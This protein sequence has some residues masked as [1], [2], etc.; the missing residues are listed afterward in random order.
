MK[1]YDN[2]NITYLGQTNWRN[3]NTPFG[4]KDPDRLRHIYCIGKSGVGKSNLLSTMAI[5]DIERGAAVGILDPH[6]DVAENLLNFI[7]KDRIE[8]VIYFNP[9]DTEFP[10]AFNPLKSIHPSHHELVASGLISTFSR[11]W[12]NSWGVRLEYILKFCLLTLLEYRNG[13]LLDINPLLTDPAFRQKVLSRCINPY[14]LAYWNNEFAKY[15]P[16]FRTEAISSILNK[17]GVF[18][19]NIALR[20]TVGQQNR[21]IN[22]QEI[23]DEGKIL[24]CNLSKGS[25]GEEACAILGSMFVTAFQTAALYRAKQPEHLR[26]PFYLYV[27]EMHSFVGLSFIDMLSEARKYGLSLFLTHQYINQ[28]SKPIQNAI[29][30]N[31]G[32]LIAFR[33][34]AADAEYLARE[35]APVFSEEDLVRLPR[36]SMYLKLMIDGTTSFPFSAETVPVKGWTKTNK[37]EVIETSQARYGRKRKVVEEEILEKYKGAPQLEERTLFD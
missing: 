20:N 29:F 26:R 24:I 21:G 15:S 27:D 14:I 8:D 10:I 22:I 19:T 12:E 25:I 30:G 2:P 13:S 31:V 36:H 37:A 16:S 33:V 35:F 18:H 17:M 1:E 23:M 6:G 28:V 34:G 9:T 5:S 32:T 7:P 11:I 3:E 4:I